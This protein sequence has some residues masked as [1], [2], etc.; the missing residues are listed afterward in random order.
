MPQEVIWTDTMY[1]FLFEM[2]MQKFG[3][4]RQGLRNDERYKT[5]CESFAEL[6]G[7]KS[8]DAVD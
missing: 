1:R 4:Y 2:L 7:V 5:F 3:P 8:G 6:I